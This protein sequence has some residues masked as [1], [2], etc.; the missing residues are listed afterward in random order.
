MKFAR[1]VLL[2]VAAALLPALAHAGAI[3]QLQQFLQQTK[4]FKAEFSQLV[5][6]KHGRKPQESS[7]VVSISRP[8]KLRWEILKPYPQ[9]IVGD[10]EKIWIYDP[11]PYPQLIVGEYTIPNCSRS[12]CANS[13]RRLVDRRRH[14]WP[15]TTI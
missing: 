10:G 4:T 2:T 13:V 6:A 12:P 1:K 3:Q 14:C 8:G 15:A 5:V 11:T 7:G 9:L